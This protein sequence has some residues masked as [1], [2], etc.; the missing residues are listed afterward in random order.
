[1]ENNIKKT[2]A[3]RGR[4]N[5]VDALLILVMLA[6]CFAALYIAD[7]FNWFSANTVRDTTLKYV[8]EIK[9]VNDDVKTNVKVGDRVFN[10]HTNN[11]IGKVTF[12][13]TQPSYRWEYVEGG[14]EMIKKTVAGK[15]DVFVTVDVICTYEKGVG[16]TVDGQQIAV[17]MPITVRTSGFVGSGYVV[18]IEEVK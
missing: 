16:Y 15:S 2:E 4:F 18:S 12:L 7:P 9:E 11:D 6:L 1:M 14:A 3:K 13:K 17:G 8:V 10:S 5:I